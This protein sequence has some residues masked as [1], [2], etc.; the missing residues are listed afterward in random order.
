MYAAALG[1]FGP[2]EFERVGGLVDEAEMAVDDV[3]VGVPGPGSVDQA[4]EMQRVL[5]RFGA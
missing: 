5:N 3:T 4:V 2:D 1:E